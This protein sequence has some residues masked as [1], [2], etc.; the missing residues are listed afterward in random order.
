M[1]SD[2]G[3]TQYNQLSR[4]TTAPPWSHQLKRAF[5][6]Q[7]YNKE[8]WVYYEIIP[9]KCFVEI[10]K[11]LLPKRSFT[12]RDLMQNLQKF[13]ILIFNNNFCIFLIFI[14]VKA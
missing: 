6:L 5:F 11:I 1:R 3:H 10:A 12:L 9:F 8:K 13:R 2:P 4:E 7:F 14:Y